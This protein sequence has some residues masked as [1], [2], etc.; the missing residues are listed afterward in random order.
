M[1]RVY[2]VNFENVAV[3]AAQDFFEVSPADDKPV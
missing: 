2:S 1:G 3:A